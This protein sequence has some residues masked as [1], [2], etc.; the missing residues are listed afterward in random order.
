MCDGVVTEVL[1]SPESKTP[2][3]FVWEGLGLNRHPELRDTYF[4]NYTRVI[5]LSQSQDPSVI[6]AAQK[7]AEQLGLKFEHIHVGVG[8]LGD[9]IPVSFI[10]H[11]FESKAKA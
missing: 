10:K 4:G 8:G 7:G 5:L 6:V 3:H 9:A 2:V 1:P 11:P